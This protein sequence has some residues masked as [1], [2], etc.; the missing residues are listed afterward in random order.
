MRVPNWQIAF[1]RI[2]ERHRA[3]QFVWGQ[4]DCLQMAAEV[5]TAVTGK[6]FRVPTGYASERAAKALIRRHGFKNLREAIASR[7]PE[8]PVSMAHRADL[9]MVRGTRGMVLA[10]CEGSHW[11]VKS[12]DGLERIPPDFIEVAFGVD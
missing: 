2:M 8:K 10:I 11:A 5:I 7:L 12:D 1:V 6:P 9:G 4:S 3:L